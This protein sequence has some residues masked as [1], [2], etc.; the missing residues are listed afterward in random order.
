MNSNAT[1]TVTFGNTNGFALTQSSFSPDAA[2][3]PHRRGFVA[4]RRRVRRC[5]HLG[6]RDRLHDHAPGRRHS[7]ERQLLGQRRRV[8]AQTAGTYTSAVAANALMTAPAG[9]NA[10]ADSAALTVN[11]PTSGGGGGRSI[12]SILVSAAL[13]L[14]A[15]RRAPHV[16]PAAAA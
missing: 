11:A 5:G 3:R 14:G 8:R 10:A 1:L 13:L 9:G 4:R 2:V 15:A 6:E 7:G 16:R 12:G